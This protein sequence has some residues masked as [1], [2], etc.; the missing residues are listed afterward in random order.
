MALETWLGFVSAV[1]VMMITPGPSQLLMLSNSMGN[2]FRRSIATAAGD[3]TANSLQMAVAGVG[4]VSVLYASRNTFLVIKWLGV[5][6]LVFMGARMILRAGS[7]GVGQPARRK[8]LKAAAPSNRIKAVKPKALRVG[9][10]TVASTRKVVGS[11][12]PPAVGSSVRA[13]LSLVP[14]PSASKKISP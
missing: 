14:S 11:E 9:I 5:G 7:G 8:S 2:G 13:L 3:L 4:L 6:Y 10:S 1:V 12:E